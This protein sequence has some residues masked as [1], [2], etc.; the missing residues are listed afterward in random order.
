MRGSAP[1]VRLDDEYWVLTHVVEY[2]APRKYYHL[3]VVLDALTYAPTRMS[4]P[5]VFEEASVEYCL[6]L[7]LG[8]EGL[9]CVYSSMDDNPRQCTIPFSSLQWI[10]M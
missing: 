4:L 9:D 2:S 1:P 3:M 6:G 8:D 7:C 5:F 10:A